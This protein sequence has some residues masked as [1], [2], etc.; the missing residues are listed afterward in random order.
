MSLLALMAIMAI[1]QGKF[2]R[3]N[4]ANLAI[5]DRGFE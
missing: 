3:A 5:N 4:I 2:I 1:M